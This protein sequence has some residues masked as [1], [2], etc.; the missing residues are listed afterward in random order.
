[1]ALMARYSGVCPDCG[2]RWQ[3]GDLI[4]AEATKL[5]EMPTWTHAVCPDDLTDALMLRANESVCQ[6]CWLV[7][8]LG[9]CDR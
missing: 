4:R 9:A 6:T 2:G 8:P 3:P 1:M 5:G 7:H